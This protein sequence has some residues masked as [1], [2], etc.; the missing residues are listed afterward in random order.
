MA[1]FKRRPENEDNDY[2][3]FLVDDLEEKEEEVP[4]EGEKA[5]E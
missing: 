4:A 5:A 2:T 3:L 1:F